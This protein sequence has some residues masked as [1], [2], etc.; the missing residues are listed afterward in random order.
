MNYT[1]EFYN[2]GANMDEI[3]SVYGGCHCITA[4]QMPMKIMSGATTA[5]NGE[6]YP[7]HAITMN[8]C[9]ICSRKESK[10]LS[11]N[12][13]VPFYI[14]EVRNKDNN[15]VILTLETYYPEDLGNLFNK[16][17]FQCLTEYRG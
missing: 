6:S 16:G 7:T 1:S 8:N 17:F 13:V 10:K 12:E 15:N 11:S 2:Y 14:L 5:K 3:E 9:Y 4:P